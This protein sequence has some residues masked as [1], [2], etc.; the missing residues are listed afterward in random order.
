MRS[1]QALQPIVP[2]KGNHGAQE[3]GGPLNQ[4]IAK[5]IKAKHGHKPVSVKNS[6]DHRKG[7][8]NGK[9]QLQRHK[10]PVGGH[11]EP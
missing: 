11:P 10:Q 2:N 3:T 9:T 5:P 7:Q 8:T 6:I 1:A 4:P